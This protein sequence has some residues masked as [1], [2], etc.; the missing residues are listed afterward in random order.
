MS[1]DP[2]RL[3][4]NMDVLLGHPG[5]VE[6]VAAFGRGPVLGAARRVLDTQRRAAAAGEAVPGVDELAARVA[7]ELERRS[8]RRTR[9]VVNATGVVLHTNLGRAPLSTAARAAVAEA[10][11]Y[12]S[13]EYDLAAGTRGRRGAA[14]EALAREVTGAEA[15]LA[16]N[17]AAGALLLAL[18]ALARGREVLVSRGEL[19]EIGGEFRLPQVMEAAGVVLREVGTTNRTHLRDYAAG[20]GPDSALVLAVHPSNYR[21]EGFTARPALAE[22]A[23][24]A[25]EHGLPL[26]HDVGSGLLAGELG[27]EPSVPGSLE[28]GADLVVFSGDKL[29]GGPQAGLVV[30]RADLVGRLARHPLARAVRADKLTLAALEATLAAHLAGRRDELPVWRALRLTAAEL[31]PRAAALAA[32]VGPAARLRPGT[33]VAGGGSLPGEGLESV[34]VEVDPAPAGEATVLARLRAGDPPVV[35]RAERG[36]VVLDLRTVP[37]E[38]DGLVARALAA[39]LN[40]GGPAAPGAPG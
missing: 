4:P 40:P 25:H 26:L 12:A 7:A 33:S 23:A 10:A 19:I 31:E 38:Q 6:R 11:G 13:V 1:T 5:L 20:F 15:A 39:A 24:L 17:N 37:P 18:G 35:A 2:R 9:A 32:A 30:G 14:A 27:A 28:A 21:V 3:L 36:R 8:A 22:L 34:L 29:V 16:V